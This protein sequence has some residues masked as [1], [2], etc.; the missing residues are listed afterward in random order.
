MRHYLGI[1]VEVTKDQLKEIELEQSSIGQPYLL[2]QIRP[3][4][5]DDDN[6]IFF[7]IKLSRLGLIFTNGGKFIF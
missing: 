4:Q 6:P 7:T 5:E 1:K 3:Y 2:D